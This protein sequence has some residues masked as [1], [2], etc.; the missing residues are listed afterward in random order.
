MGGRVGAVVTLMALGLAVP[1]IALADNPPRPDS[2]QQPLKDGCQRSPA[3]LLTYA[4]GGPPQTPEWSY[5]YRDPTVRL[6][7]GIAHASSPAGGDLP[8][9]HDWYDMNYNLDL[10]P[11]YG[12]LLGGDPNA[13][14]GNFAPGSEDTN[15][16]HLEWETGTLPAWAWP[17]ENDRVKTW[18][19][20]IWDCG[21]WG[22]NFEDPDYFLPGTGE[23]PFSENVRGEQTEFHPMR[24]IVV[25]RA[26]PYRPASSESEAD[27]FISSDGTRA[28]VEEECA[29][30]NPPTFPGYYPPGFTDCV[31]AETNRR[32][33]VNDRDYS[34]FLPAP[35]RPSRSARLQYRIVD[36]TGGQQPHED[37]AVRRTGIEVTIRFTGFGGDS[38]PLHY[39][40]SFFLGWSGE[41]PTPPARLQ[42]QLDRLTVFHSL[43]PN[44]DHP[45]QFAPPPGEYGL[46]IDVNGWWKYLN[47]WAPGLDAVSDGQSFALGR[48][49]EIDVPAG[50]G[51]RLFTHG[52]ECD[53][54]RILPCPDVK[55]GADDNDSPG[56]TLATFA[57]PA[58]ALGD[59]RLRPESGNYEL[60][61]SVRPIEAGG[62]VDRTAP[63][64][65]F[66]R[67]G[68]R[69][70]HRG[71][72]VRGFATDAGCASPRVARVQAALALR[73][74]G[75]C[76]WLGARNR[77]SR[78]AS[79]ARPR[80]LRV[81]GTRRWRLTRRARLPSGRY[82][83]LTRA[84]DRAGNLQRRPVRT[85]RR[86]R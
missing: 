5:V 39:G 51:L 20:W 14:N 35:R 40:K 44:S 8:H 69:L 86:L 43:D 1:P 6:A 12:Y 75:G 17:T 62:C 23:T 73:V 19:S 63:R 18:G 71:V 76:R 50:H 3:P 32:Q 55:E 31:Q 79:C 68:V 60:T 64:S 59:H 42:V 28:R 61:Y 53:I 25:T 67:R 56:D 16:L 72:R 7:E 9:G 54:P 45:S 2:Q 70:T 27:V 46:Y 26:A 57:S 13:K 66:A 82:L 49:V 65:R 37:V 74:R 84:R 85:T 78:R 81:R 48:A 15:R 47:D 10:D 29:R 38:A 80:W 52:R 33:P 41:D 30:L 36:M 83:L 77:L 24:A 22:Q 58:A 34:F 4:A 11:Q 21:H